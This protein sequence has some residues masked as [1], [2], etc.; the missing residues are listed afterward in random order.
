MTLYWEIIFNRC[1]DLSSPALRILERRPPAENAVTGTTRN[2]VKMHMLDD[3]T[4]CRAIVA[5]H[6]VPFGANRFRHRPSQKT[7]DLGQ[8][9]Q[10]IR[11]T[12][13]KAAVVSLRNNQRVPV[14]D[15]ANIQK[16]R[17]LAVFKYPD[18]WNS[19]GRYTPKYTV[20]F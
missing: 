17:H 3:L 1:S 20:R 10:N 9:G 13:I 16:R 14:T 12:L 18:T 6:I 2:N 4:G 7:D 15:R 8:L 19:A 11:R 5:Q